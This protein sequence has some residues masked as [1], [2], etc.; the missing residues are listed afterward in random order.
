MKPSVLALRARTLVAVSGTAARGY[1]VSRVGAARLALRLR[2]R[3]GFDVESALM[4]GLLD[5]AM[6]DRTRFAHMGRAV[7][8]V[9]QNRLDPLSLW[10]ISE[11]K[12]HFYDYMRASGV[13]VPEVFG[14]V[15]AAGVWS[16]RDGAVV[17]G[18]DAV[19]RFLGGLPGDLVVKP[20][21][22]ARAVGV[23]VLV[24]AREGFED[25]RGEPVDMRV[26]ADDLRADPSDVHLVQER[27]VNHPLIEEITGSPVL[28]TVRIVAI[29]RPDG[30][31]FLVFAVLK[32]VLGTAD[33]D[34]FLSGSTGNGY[35]LMTLDDGR[36]GDLTVR[37]PEGYG[38]TSTPVVPSTG[39]RVR[40]RPVPF[41]EEACDLV[42]R[43][44]AL[45]LPMRTLGWDVAITPDGPVI[46]ESNV[47][48]AP[49]G[50]MTA[51]AWALLTG[52][53]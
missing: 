51:E 18:P 3:N 35:S 4:D 19:A 26:L 40:G 30:S 33:T 20:S 47:W 29:V 43:A 36:L 13:P 28:Q 34:N 24:R 52:E 11:Q 6:D 9:S 31:V 50:P 14:T 32:L 25:L 53:R 38:F 42:R 8:H 49:F 21:Y 46:L 7:R 5:P 12:L 44:S 15:G 17:T 41:F 10:P 37:A 27:L 23:R 39:V 45:M 16:R 2:R 1:G 48:W 22:G